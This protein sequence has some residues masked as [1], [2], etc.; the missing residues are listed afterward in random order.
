MQDLDVYNENGAVLLLDKPLGWTSFDVVNKIRYAGKFKKVGHAGTLDPLATGLLILCVGKMTKQIETFQAQVKEYTGT[1]TLGK[2][3][4]SFDLET[5]FDGEYTT[6]HITSEKLQ[7]AKEQLTGTIEQ[8]PPAHSAIKVNGKRAYESARKGQ[9][10]A[11]KSRSVTVSEF[12]IDSKD[13][14]IIQFRIV[15][16]KGTYIRTI[17]ND[18]GK[19]LNSGA[20][21]SSLRRT[22]I[23]EFGV[24]NAEDVL[25]LAQKINSIRESL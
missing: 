8:T 24:E 25:S 16:T 23:G 17:A 1:F 19:I 18:F 3:T 15:C 21:L 11:L 2:T 7:E 6:D 13:F 14:P 12:E 22:K 5:E 10:V 9:E 20:H 4:P